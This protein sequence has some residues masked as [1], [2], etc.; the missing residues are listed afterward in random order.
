MS[1]KTEPDRLIHTYGR[2]HGR[3]LR[4]GQQALRRDLLPRLAVAVD[5]DGRVDPRALFD[6]GI[7]SV[8][9]EIGFGGGEHLA[10]QAASHPDAGIIGCEPYVNGVVSLL[11]QVRA[12]GLGNVR[13]W[14]G[15][16]RP[17]L[18]A[19]PDRS[20]ARVFVL[21]PDPWPKARHHKRRL[22]AAPV[23]DELAR[24][25]APGGELRLA[26][27]D[28][29]Y[30]A[31]MLE[32]L[33]AHAAFRWTAQRPADWRV[34]PPDWPETRYEAKAAAA[35]R[36]PAYLRFSRVDARQDG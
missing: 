26:T 10:A 11:A 13:I 21:F 3:R 19:L 7:R 2:R 36:R 27:D 14:P 9:L 1:T 8:W 24:V 32:R 18:R 22:V 4:P 28:A 31:W 5:A 30:L 16:A 6:A 23:L 29:D 34:R 12:R 17:L 33:T 20:V 35:G 25:L 15:D